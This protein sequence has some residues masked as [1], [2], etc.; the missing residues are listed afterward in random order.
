[1]QRIKELENKIKSLESGEIKPEE[2][3]LSE[4]KEEERHEEKE[5]QGPPQN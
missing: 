4:I 2:K 1:M 5:E 3:Q